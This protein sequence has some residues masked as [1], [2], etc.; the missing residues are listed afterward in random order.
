MQTLKPPKFKKKLP[1]NV[2]N[3][4]SGEK[5]VKYINL[6]CILGDPEIVSSL[7]ITPETFS[8]PVVTCELGLPI[9]TNVFNFYKFVNLLD[10][11]GFL[12]NSHIL[13]CECANSPL[14]HKYIIIGDLRTINDNRSRNTFC[15]SPK[16]KENKSVNADKAKSCILSGLEDC[17]DNF[18]SKPGIHESILSGLR[19]LRKESTPGL[20]FYISLSINIKP[21]KSLE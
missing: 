13:P 7:P 16:H 3:I 1:K 20:L 2:C 11:N 15:R 19:R 21:F 4:F 12:S 10:L 14:V 8:I 17:V 18:C 5:G 6:A 9:S